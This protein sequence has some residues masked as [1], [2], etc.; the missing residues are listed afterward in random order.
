MTYCAGLA[1][2]T[3]G[4]MTSDLLTWY[5]IHSRSDRDVAFDEMKARGFDDS[6][7]CLLSFKSISVDMPRASPA[8]WRSSTRCR[9]NP[10]APQDHNLQCH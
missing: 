10:L 1:I 9:M 8:E 6:P 5:S 4:T 3:V 2:A 7:A